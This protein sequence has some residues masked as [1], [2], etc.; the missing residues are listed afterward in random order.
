MIALVTCAWAGSAGLYGG[1]LAFKGPARHDLRPAV[2]AWG[3]VP[4]GPLQLTA[5]LLGTGRS[6]ASI[7]H[8]V[9]LGRASAAIG[10]DTGDRV[11]IGV[12]AGPA[13]VLRAGSAGGHGFTDFAPALRTLA[14]FDLTLGKTP[15][16]AR[17]QMGTTTRAL[18]AWDFDAAVGLGVAW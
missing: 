9:I 12:A 1:P 18:Y 14:H 6:R 16:V 11:N 17:Y 4:V 5:E 8:Q 10:V 15:L 2:G 3:R 7:E 13:L